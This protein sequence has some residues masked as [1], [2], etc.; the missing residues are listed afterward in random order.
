MLQNR[1]RAVIGPKGSGKSYRSAKMF[2]MCKRAV[3][4]DIAHDE[5]YYRHA[6]H[7]V[8]DTQQLFKVMRREEEFRA[9]YVVSEA[10]LMPKG[11]ELIYISAVPVV[12]ECFFIGNMTLFLDEA[13]ELCTQWSIDWRIRKVVRL[14]RH[15]QLNIVWISQSM[16]EIHREIRRNTDEYHFFKIHEPADLEAIKLRCGEPCAL[17]V[18]SLLRLKKHPFTPGT[19]FVWV[20]DEQ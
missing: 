18:A 6:T 17:K 11:K 2:A 3:L 10:D 15:Q 19:C 16:N 1:I 8:T 5:D 14:A 7:I 20:S 9:I 4:Y 12:E 13:H